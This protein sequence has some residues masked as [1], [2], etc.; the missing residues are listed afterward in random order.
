ME[1]LRVSQACPCDKLRNRHGVFTFSCLIPC[2]SARSTLVRTNIVLCPKN[3][4]V[5]VILIDHDVIIIY[6]S[7]EFSSY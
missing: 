5:H 4:Y 6:N 2:F 1:I 3:V 7:G